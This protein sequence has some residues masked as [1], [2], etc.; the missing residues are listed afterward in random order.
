MSNSDD[1][2]SITTES[3]VTTV[4]IKNLYGWHAFLDMRLDL[5]GFIFRGQNQE[6]W[7]LQ[8]SFSRLINNKESYQIL[9]N[10]IPKYHGLQHRLP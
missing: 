9:L 10:C 5:K 7:S 1:Y 6:S 3:N 4:T 8:P 2:M